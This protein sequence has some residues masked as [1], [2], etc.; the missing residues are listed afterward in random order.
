MKP[1]PIHAT[2]EDTEINI[3]D[4]TQVK[5]WVHELGVTEDQLRDAVMNTGTKLGDVE[6][7]LANR[8]I[9]DETDVT[10][11][12]DMPDWQKTEDTVTTPPPGKA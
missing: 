12:E 5:H 6:K 3:N 11:T 9:Q 7:E 10:P 4:E 1:K 8:K 2:A